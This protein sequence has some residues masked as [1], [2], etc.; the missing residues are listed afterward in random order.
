MKDGF[1]KREAV[2]LRVYLIVVFIVKGT[3]QM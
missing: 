2:L 1:L 3:P